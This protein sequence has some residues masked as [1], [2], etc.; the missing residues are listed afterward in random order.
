[1]VERQTLREPTA[2]GDP[3]DMGARDLQCVEHTDGVRDEIGLAVL[4]RARLVADRLPGIAQVVADHVSPAGRESLAEFVLPP[5]HRARGPG[6]QQNRRG[7]TI[8]EGLDAEVDPVGLHS[9]QDVA[10][11]AA[12]SSPT[13][14]ALGFIQ[15]ISQ[16]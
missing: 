2:H 11:P 6:D 15:K 13:S 10:A 5:V 7:G 8:T 4:G 3:D 16:R 9:R 14:R 12:V 1:M